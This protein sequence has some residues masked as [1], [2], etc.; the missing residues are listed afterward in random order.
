MAKILLIEP[1]Y[2]NKYPPLG[3][4]KISTY[5]KQQGDEVVFYKGKNKDL[6]DEKWDRIYIATLFTFYWKKTIDTIKFYLNSVENSSNIF[7]GGVMATVLYDKLIEEEDIKGI[8]IFKGLLDKPNMLNPND[9]LIVDTLTPDYSIIE[10]N[11][12]QKYKYPV[13]DAYIAYATKGC[14]NKCEFCVVPTLEPK[15]KDYISIKEQVGKIKEKY[16]E[17]RDLL[18]LDNNVLASNELERIIQDIIDLGY[19][20]D[21]NFFRYEKNGRK[22]SRRKY[23]DFNQGVDARLINEENIR[24]LSKIAIKPL[25]VAFDHAEDSYVSIYSKAV[26]L[27]ANHG[28]K[29]LSNFLLFNFKD[30]P[31]DLYKRIKINI[32]LNE[33]FEADDKT[34]GAKIFS[35]PM[36]YS[37]PKGSHSM[38]RKFIGKHWEPKYIRTIQCILAA[39]HGVVGPKRSFF[40]KAYGTSMDEFN[41]L[42]LMPEDY[43]IYRGSH[44]D[45]GDTDEW[46]NSFEKLEDKSRILPTILSNNLKKIDLNQ[47][48][49]DEKAVMIHYVPSK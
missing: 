25:R 2:K 38:D 21:D 7:V 34:N 23:V 35:F 10:H 48:S 43:I 13:D 14:V 20:V 30:T 36:R 41:K 45:S 33:E 22:I 1:D 5:H 24:L 16:G 4:M 3:L 18:L 17:K 28:I 29:N 49:E 27:A 42:L 26:R 15:Y 19:G 37:P 12:T 46:W 32:E 31:Q 11:E 40:E 44:K 8:K 6:R 47:F 39:T 9:N